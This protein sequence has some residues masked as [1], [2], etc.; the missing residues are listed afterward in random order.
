MMGN[1]LKTISITVMHYCY[2]SHSLQV[3]ALHR[4]MLAFS[5]LLVVTGLSGYELVTRP[6]LKNHAHWIAA[7]LI[8]NPGT[9]SQAT[10]TN[11]ISLL[12]QR[13]LIGI[14]IVPISLQSHSSY[15]HIILPFDQMLADQISQRSLTT[16]R[17]SS[18]IQFANLAINCD[19]RTIHLQIYHDDILGATPDLALL[20]WIIS[21][22]IGGI[23]L[24]V[25]LSRA[26]TVPLKKLSDELR[27]TPLTVT[28]NRT[29]AIGISE[30]DQLG[31]EIEALR[32]RANR[33]IAT[34]SAL[35]MGLSHDLRKPLARIRLI[36]ETTT[37]PCE[38]DI[39][40]IRRDVIELQDAMDEFM[41]AAN[42]IASPTQANGA[43]IGWMRLK[44]MYRD[45]RLYF[46]E[47]PNNTCPALN[48]A[49]LIRVA[50]QLIDNALRHT[51]GMVTI[52]WDNDWHLC[53]LDQGP[54][55]PPE[56][57]QDAC[58]PF[59]STGSTDPD[60]AGLGLALASIICEHNGWQLAFDTHPDGGWMACIQP[61]KKH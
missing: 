15:W 27:T 34:R 59:W 43:I 42:A 20:L 13:N 39:A 45:Q 57:I 17:V 41:R 4:I 28:S 2:Q 18:S 22:L 8:P 52:M 31:G 23:G 61:L 56:C 37:I 9:C 12:R 55:I 60:H 47:Q 48:A 6:A 33:T 44:A 24:A 53:V 38:A 32:N 50:S 26:L 7:D 51:D 25:L 40:D 58:N 54:G 16:V 36:A 10:I 14:D 21:L 30:L 1:L 29:P 49:A 19:H 11:R 5:I 3:F 46:I 35:L